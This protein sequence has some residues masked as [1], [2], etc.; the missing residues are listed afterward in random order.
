MLYHLILSIMSFF[1][2]FYI[3]RPKPSRILYVVMLF[4]LFVVTAFRWAVGCDFFSYYNL[5]T[6]KGPATWE[7]AFTRME[8][9][10]WSAV[11]LLQQLGLD[12]SYINV[13]SAL[14]FFAGLHAI[15]RRQ[16]EF[17]YVFDPSV[18][19]SHRGLGDVGC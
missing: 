6:L 16:P 10:Y 4:V 13:L 2:V 1:S 12:W 9:A 3:S 5:A 17:A 7:D 8:P 11:F 18:S 15:A 14:S 19:R